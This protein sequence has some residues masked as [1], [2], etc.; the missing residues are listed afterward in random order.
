MTNEAVYQKLVQVAKARK[1]IAYG[2]L[3]QTADVSIDGDDAMKVIGD[4]LDAIADQEVAAGRPLLPIVVV[5]GKTNM[6]GGGLFKYAKRKKL[7][8]GD[9]LTF[10]ATELRRVYD[11][12]E[13][14]ETPAG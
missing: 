4:I 7:Q 5:S 6:P 12:W 9:D 3:A 8:K 1:S 14:A 13:K 11:F 10:F 2:E